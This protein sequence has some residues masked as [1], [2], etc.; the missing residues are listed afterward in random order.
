MRFLEYRFDFL[1][2]KRLRFTTFTRFAVEFRT[3]LSL[4]L[5][6]FC[7]CLVRLV[8]VKVTSRFY[9]PFEPGPPSL[10][11]ASDGLLENSAGLF[12]LQAFI[13]LILSLLLGRHDVLYNVLLVHW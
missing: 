1:N 12:V 3:F 10:S 4:I 9:I 8:L 11:V 2:V 13:Y 5:N 7:T 6:R